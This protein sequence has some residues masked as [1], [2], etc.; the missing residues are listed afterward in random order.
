MI[1]YH[2]KWEYTGKFAARLDDVLN[3]IPARLSGLF[4]TLASAIRGADFA[5]SWHTMLGQHGRTE[6]P[7]AGW[8]MS[9]MAGALGITLEKPGAYSLNGGGRELTLDAITRSQQIV[10]AAAAIWIMIVTGIE[11]MIGIAA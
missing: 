9:A 10:M 5:G 6:S 1:G 3:F 2:G 8:T 11:V 7:N 4:I